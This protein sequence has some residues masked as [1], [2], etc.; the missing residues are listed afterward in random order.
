MVSQ[1]QQRMNPLRLA[2]VVV[3]LLTGASVG[4]NAAVTR[5]VDAVKAGDR[6]AVRSLLQQSADVNAPDVDG[7]TALH[8]A[9]R[10]DDIDTV[11]LLLT[12][13]ADATAANRYGVTALSL[14]VTNGSSTLTRMLLEAG[15]DANAAL[16]EGETVLMTAAYNGRLEPIRMLLDY[17]ADPNAHERSFGETALMWAAALNQ[18]AAI[19]VL[20]DGGADVNARSAVANY[21]RPR[22]P[23]TVL[24][25]GGWTPLMYA[26]RQ[27]A[28]EAVRTLVDAGADLNL[29]DPDGTTALVLAII[30]AHYRLAAMLVEKGA[31][32]NVADEAG[33]AALYAAIDMHTLPWLFGSPEPKTNDPRESFEMVKL[34]LAHGAD[35][36][37]RL[38]RSPLQRLHTPGD[39]VMAEGATPFMR[40]AKAGDIA[41]MRLLLDH[42]ANPALVQKNGTTALIIAAGLGWQDGGANLNTRDRGTQGD[43]INAIRLCLQQGLDIHAVN[44]SGTGVL[45][46]A[47]LRGDAADIIRFLVANGARVDAKNYQGQTA[48]DLALA[49]RGQDGAAAVIPSTVNLF[50]QLLAAHGVT[51]T[52]DTR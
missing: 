24:P 48:L 21:S 27:G 38:Q 16:L 5:L 23:I 26:A 29:R 2:S 1:V 9:V 10:A 3:A 30:N 46:A 41:V 39:P 36:N 22:T 32:L 52:S 15:A 50:R 37:A 45:H 33:M 13:G 19:R 43:A 8:W 35:P 44:D 34:L 12:S 4:A 47:A 17:G 42:G 49:R 31:D 18:A 6:K 40:A 11:R 20:I 51:T 25:R 14:A 7:T 28:I